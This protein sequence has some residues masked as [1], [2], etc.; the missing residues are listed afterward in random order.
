MSVLMFL[1]TGGGTLWKSISRDKGE[2]WSAAE[3]TELVAARSSHS[4]FRTADGRI[5]FTRNETPDDRF[6]L[7]LRVSDDDAA[8]WGAPLKLAEVDNRDAKGGSCQA[9][10]PSV[11][12]L[13]D[14]TPLVTATQHGLGQIVFFHVTANSDWSNLPLSGLFVD[15]LKKLIEASPLQLARETAAKSATEGGEAKKIGRAHV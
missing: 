5:V 12:Q 1:R 15:M 14:G 11:T 9:S 13:A 10:Y 6:L 2:T 7:T 8:T 3:K 4:L